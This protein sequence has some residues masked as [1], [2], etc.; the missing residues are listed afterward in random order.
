[1]SSSY[2]MRRHPILGYRRMHRGLDFKAGHGQ[3]IVAVTDGRVSY[4]GR[5]GGLGKFV[6][7][8]HAGGLSTGYAHMSRIAVNNGAQVR[9]GQVIGYVGSTGLS[10]GP[11]LHYEMYR[12]GKHVNPSSVRF[13]TRAQLEGSELREFRSRLEALKTVDAGAALED[14]VPEASEREQPVREIDK[15]ETPREVG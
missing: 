7:V 1:V 6:R 8:N 5:K 12:G 9:R 13:V 14:L 3:P 10:S 15:I 2:G 4:A 11:H